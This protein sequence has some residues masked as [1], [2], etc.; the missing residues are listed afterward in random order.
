MKNT[1]IVDVRHN[2]KKTNA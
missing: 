2:A 1:G